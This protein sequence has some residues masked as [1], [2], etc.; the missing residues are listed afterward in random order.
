[1]KEG[2]QQRCPHYGGIRM[3]EARKNISPEMA[4]ILFPGERSIVDEEWDEYWAG[5][6]AANQGKR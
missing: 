6:S 4:R 1:V 2:E 5:V 3:I